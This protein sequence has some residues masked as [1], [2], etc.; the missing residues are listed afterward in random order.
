MSTVDLRGL[1]DLKRA[2]LEALLG[3][4]LPAGE[5]LYVES[6]RQATLIAQAQEALTDA[7]SAVLNHLPFDLLALDCERALSALGEITGEVTQ[8]DILEHMF[9]SFCVGK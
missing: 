9:S 4:T 6:K 2:L 1:D 8:E 5:R 7:K 3:L